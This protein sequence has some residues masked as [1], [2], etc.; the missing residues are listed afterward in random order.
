MYRFVESL[1]EYKQ[2]EGTRQWQAKLLNDSCKL[3][4]AEQTGQ[5]PLV[6]LFSDDAELT[7]LPELSL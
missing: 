3:Q 4:E 1:V 2:V 5:P 6:E 7:T